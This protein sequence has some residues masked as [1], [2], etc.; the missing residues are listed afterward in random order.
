MKHFKQIYFYLHLIDA[1]K[2]LFFAIIIFWFYEKKKNLYFH[3]ELYSK[4]EYIANKIKN[5]FFNSPSPILPPPPP[6]NNLIHLIPILL[7]FMKLM[8][9]IKTW[10]NIGLITFLPCQFN[11][12]RS[13][14]WGASPWFCG[15]PRCIMEVIAVLIHFPLLFFFF[16]F[17]LMYARS[18]NNLTTHLPHTVS[19]TSYRF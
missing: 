18:D 17:S 8:S 6:H 16:S 1:E 7:R 9:L 19:H 10:D 3:I 4:W 5:D 2:K 15:S 13:L 14:G 12:R 11:C